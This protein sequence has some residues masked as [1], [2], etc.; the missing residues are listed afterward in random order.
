MGFFNRFFNKIDI[1]ECRQVLRQ[2]NPYFIELSRQNQ[3][4]FVKRTVAFINRARFSSERGF[5]VDNPIKI[6]VSSAF[7]QITFGLKEYTLKEH[8]NIFI[9]PA[10]YTYPGHDHPM[11]GD[12]NLQTKTI[13]LSWPSVVKGFEV[14]DDAINIAIHEFGHCLA[15]ENFSQRYLGRFLQDIHW[16]DWAQQATVKLGQVKAGQNQVLRKYGGNNLMELFA[17]SLENFF[18]RPEL[19]KNHLPEFY[20]SL[21][22]LLNQD[23]IN[24]AD[25]VIK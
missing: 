25:P 3:D 21:C 15:F 5:T 10:S 2:S 14:P 4:R 22:N 7:I 16:Q 24:K 6:I 19:F 12:V 20:Q 13:S 18:E 17:V 9:A 1:H 8:R 23:P 11:S